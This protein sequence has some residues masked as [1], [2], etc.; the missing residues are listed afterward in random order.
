MSI[1]GHVVFEL[2]CRSIRR[3]FFLSGTPVAVCEP[4]G[5]SIEPTSFG[6]VLSEMSKMWTPSK[7]AGTGWPPHVVVPEAGASQVRTTMFL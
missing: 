6:A 4:Q 5:R 7:P 3:L 2:P 1:H